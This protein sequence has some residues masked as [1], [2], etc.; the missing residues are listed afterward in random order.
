MVIM[1]IIYETY[2]ISQAC[3]H[4]KRKLV[5]L[6]NYPISQFSCRINSMGKFLNSY[7][8]IH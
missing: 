5:S 6:S 1:P 4:L 3:F 8:I 2:S 7:G